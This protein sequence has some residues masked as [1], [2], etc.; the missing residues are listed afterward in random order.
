MCVLIIEIVCGLIDFT[1]KNKTKIVHKGFFRVC[2]NCTWFLVFN[3]RC[4]HGGLYI[5]K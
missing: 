1:K 3:E 4:P 2:C 5:L